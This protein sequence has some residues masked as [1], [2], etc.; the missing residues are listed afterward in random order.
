[1]PFP[2]WTHLSLSCTTGRGI[3]R[4]VIADS[5]NCLK[6]DLVLGS[7][8][9]NFSFALKTLCKSLS[10][11][12]TTESAPGSCSAKSTLDRIRGQPPRF[13][14]QGIGPGRIPIQI[15][16]FP[17]IPKL[18]HLQNGPKTQILP[19]Q[20]PSPHDPQKRPR[21]FK[22]HV[23]AD[24]G[25][26]EAMY[27]YAECLGND[28][29]VEPDILACVRPSKMPAESAVRI[30]GIRGVSANM[31]PGSIPA[32][33]SASPTVRLKSHG[34]STA[35]HHDRGQWIISFDAWSSW[36]VCP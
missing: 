8:A 15:H 4:W 7:V 19:P 23:S 26:S 31:R 24:F 29:G 35:C 12:P 27:E 20:I 6:D 28:R 32:N 25:H 3:D 9:R 22:I 11:N 10:H 13:W 33:A 1:M 18:P 17:S 36:R 34:G 5:G 21:Y 30:W 16:I 2:K 14:S